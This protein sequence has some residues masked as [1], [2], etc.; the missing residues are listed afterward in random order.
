MRAWIYLG[1]R[2]LPAADISHYR[3]YDHTHSSLSRIKD[4]IQDAI[5]S[6]N[7]GRN[8]GRNIQKRM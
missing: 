6:K 5:A 4:L 7:G 2:Q 3:I 1:E 8:V